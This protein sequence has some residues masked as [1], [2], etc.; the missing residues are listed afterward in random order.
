MEVFRGRTADEVWRLAFRGVTNNAAVG[1]AQSSRAG[2]T[3]EL[4]HAILEVQDPR[5]RWVVSR[6]PALNPAF[7]IAEIIWLL[8]GSNDAA[9]LN[10]WFPALPKYAGAGPTYPGAYGRR[11]RGHFGVD[12]L[13]RAC[14]VLTATPDSRQVLLQIWDPRVDLP[15]QA[16]TPSSEDIP[17]NVCAMLKLREGRLE[18]TQVMRSSDIYR[19]LPYDL[20]QFTFLQELLAGWLGVNV[21][22]YCHWSDSLHVYRKATQELRCEEDATQVL[23]T[24][25]LTGVSGSEDLFRELYRRLVELTRPDLSAANVLDLSVLTE[26]SA[27]HQNLLRIL[28]AESARRR[29]QLD[30]ASEIMAD[31]TNP[32][33]IR[34][35]SSWRDR[36]R[37]NDRPRDS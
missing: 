36:F 21:G 14:D 10:Y 32:Q 1:K 9:A 34:V 12:Q 26:G 28:A 37:V 22:S 16:G 29:N 15:E 7:A 5:Q 8:A 25:S 18:W 31:C 30:I 6:R 3:F 33:L 23:D 20:F 27:A 24:D 11:L 35:W 2:D 4:L 17:C 13:R 19:G